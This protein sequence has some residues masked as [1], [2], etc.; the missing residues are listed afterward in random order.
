MASEKISVGLVN[1]S[2]TKGWI[3]A[4]TI[5]TTAPVLA[6]GYIDTADDMTTD[7][8]V[9][10]ISITGTMRTLVNSY[11]YSGVGGLGQTGTGLYGIYDPVDWT[12]KQL[13]QCNNNT[14]AGSVRP[15]IAGV[16]QWSLTNPYGI[17]TD[18]NTMY[19][20]GNDSHPQ[21]RKAFIYSYNMAADAFSENSVPVYSFSPDITGVQTQW[22]GAGYG[23]DIYTSGNNKYLIAVFGR[24]TNVG[25]TYTQGP[26]A[27]VKIPLNGSGMVQMAITNANPTGVVVHG[28]Y[29]YVTSVGGAQVGGGNQ[30]SKLE[31]FNIAGTTLNYLVQIDVNAIPSGAG[32]TGGDYVDVAFASGKAYVLAAHYNNNYTQYEYIIIETVET[33]LIDGKLNKK[34][35]SGYYTIVPNY[36]RLTANPASPTFGLLPGEGDDL[37]LVD[38]V[39]IKKIDTTVSLTESV[40]TLVK[41][42]GDFALDSSI[43]GHVFNTAGVVVERTAPVIT[44]VATGVASA[45]VCVTKMA[46]RLAHL[47]ELEPREG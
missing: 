1:S 23:L 3:G 43:I 6:V 16:Q 32:F 39:N 45:K 38:G 41:S 22:K 14:T 47:E 28:D 37:Y 24:F 20:I 40:V 44:P 31:V 17:V 18:G 34:D 10:P 8:R 46:K 9:L 29:A 36:V 19:M 5:G 11:D 30:N 33:S 35:S 7:P 25:W 27:I 4:Y 13:A 2:Y 26:G 21:N 15:P 42:A 12:R